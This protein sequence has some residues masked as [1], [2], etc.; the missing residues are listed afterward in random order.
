[1]IPEMVPDFIPIPFFIY[2]TWK[3][4]LNHYHQ[5]VVDVI[6]YM[7]QYSLDLYILLVA[8]KFTSVLLLNRKSICT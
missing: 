5:S 4:I 1:M 6:F 8:L 2:F 7:S 3:Y